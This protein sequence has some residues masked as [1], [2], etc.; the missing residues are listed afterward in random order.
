MFMEVLC[1]YRHCP[2]CYNVET[3]SDDYVRYN[4]KNYHKLCGQ[5]QKERD[6]L[7]AYLCFILG[8][9]KPG[10]RIESQINT[11]K[12]K[13]GYTYVGM[14]QALEYFYEVQK[15]KDRMDIENKSVGIIPYV[16]AEAAEYY[17]KRETLKDKLEEESKNVGES[18][19]VVV[20]MPEK[21]IKKPR[22]SLDDIK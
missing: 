8:L 9:K 4:N 7:V 20:K 6:E 18:N 3:K 13:Y 19:V 22:Y 17:R 5:L 2:Y 16:Y 15:H 10:P 21:Q 11:F 1:K 14:K 12:D